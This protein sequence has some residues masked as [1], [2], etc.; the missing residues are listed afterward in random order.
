MDPQVNLDEQLQ[1]SAAILKI[2]DEGSGELTNSQNEEVAEMA[3]RLAE[4]VSCLNAWI[5]KGGV[6]PVSWVGGR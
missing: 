4:L 3:E 1:L 6:P 2:V 5:V